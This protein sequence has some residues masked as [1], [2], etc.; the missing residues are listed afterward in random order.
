MKHIFTTIWI[1]LLAL[2]ISSFAQ[3]RAQNLGGGMGFGGAL[4][5]SDDG[6]GLSSDVRLSFRGFVR[7]SFTDVLEGEL[8]VGFGNKIESKNGAET[9]VLPLDGRLLVRPFVQEFWSPYFYAGLGALRYHVETLPTNATSGIDNSGWTAYVPLGVGLQFRVND[10]TSFE[11][12]G[13]YNYTF[14]DNLNGVDLDASN[15]GYFNA[16]AGLT[17]AGFNWGAN[18]DGDG[19]TNREEKKLGTDMH[20]ADTDGDGLTDGEEFLQFSSNPL[21]ADSDGDG[22]N[23]F[24]EVKTHKTDPNKADTD[25]DGLNDKDE[26]LTYQTDPLKADTDDDGLSDKDELMTYKSD[27]LRRDMDNDGL[28]DGDEVL[29]YKTDFAKADTDGDGLNDG[30]EV[31]KHKTNPLM[32]DSDNGSVNDGAE[33]ARGTNPLNA[34]DDALLK[35][36]KVGS[37]IVLEGVVFATGSAKITDASKDVL[38][39]AFKTLQAYPDMIVEVRG[40][41]DN[42]GSL[43]GNMRLSEARAKSVK[44]YLDNLGISANR[45]TAKGFGPQ[46]PIASNTTREGRRK[47]RR[48][49][50]VRVK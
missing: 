43:R 31:R 7:H 10:N 20:N 5:W 26:A 48:I 50:F 24:V 39:K 29:T 33:V 12:N 45:I 18:P 15:D 1:A 13:G 40:Y 34:D 4:G 28:S 21:I 9:Q 30:D 25:D 22:L 41:T 17:M 35:V 37:K 14:S 32:A 16:Q 42:T 2:T 49:E 3:F 6:G 8:S 46:D 19:L 38:E 23:D 27:P 44:S 47:N 36:S 11:V